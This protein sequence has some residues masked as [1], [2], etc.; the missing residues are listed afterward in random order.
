MPTTYG[1]TEAGFLTKP[2]EDIAAELGS[3]LAVA[4]G[5]AIDLAPQSNWGQVVGIFSER[6]ALL[7]QLGEALYTALT[8]DGAEGVPLDNLCALTGTAREAPTKSRVTATCCGTAGTLIPYGKAASVLTTAA[9][10]VTTNNFTLLLVPAWN[11]TTPDYATG[12]RVRN[13]GKI[14][15]L[16]S[17]AYV[18]PTGDAVPAGVGV[19]QT[20]GPVDGDDAVWLCIGEGTGAVD[21]DFQAE[22]AG[23]VNCNTGT[24]T[25]IESPV[26]GWST[27][28][29]TEDAYLIGSALESDPVLRM[30]RE[31]ELR[32]IGNAAVE[33]IRA[34]VDAVENVTSCV[35]F[36]NV[37]DATDGNGLLPHTVEVVVEAPDL[38]E[39]NDAIRTAIWESVGGGIGTMGTVTGEVEDEDGVLWPVNFS[40]TEK[41]EVYA[42][43]EASIDPDKYPA[44]GADQ[45]KAA[46]LAFA[47]LTYKNGTD[48]ISA[49]L[50]ARPFQT[51]GVVDCVTKISTT[52][53]PTGTA[54]L[55]MSMRQRAVFDSAR[56]EVVATPRATS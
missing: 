30:R 3:D 16:I 42:K 54:T 40:R 43:V 20:V 45:I 35:V 11:P 21:A 17:P 29:N 53:G 34:R 32:A 55:P 22:Q 9:R 26:G 13:D 12:D 36:E 6:L 39:V 2:Q 50:N 1:L 47:A 4:F 37:T 44:D 19:G 46:L 48:V 33:A 41:V 15:E 10:F 28:Y 23:P 31:E 18:T 49:A 25:R 7:W 5:A 52:P 14:W 51:A 56:I 27:V 38:A 24:L 8:A